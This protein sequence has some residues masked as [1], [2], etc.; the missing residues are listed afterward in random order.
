MIRL[1]FLVLQNL[2]VQN[3]NL[4]EQAALNEKDCSKKKQNVKF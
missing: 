2:E 4:M 3:K 1:Y